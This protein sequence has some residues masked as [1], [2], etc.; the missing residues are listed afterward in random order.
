MRL[1][2]VIANMERII[3][4]ERLFEQG[5]TVVVAVSGGPD[6]VALLHVLF[7][8]SA[9]YDWSLVAAHVNHQFRGK[10]SDAEAEMVA[11]LANKLKIPLRVGVIDVPAYI[12]ETG[13]NPQAAA[14]EKR[15]A[16][17]HE[18]A[19][20]FAA[21]HIALAHH[22]DD[23]AET[24]IMRLLR[25]TGPSGLGGIPLRRRE[26]NVELVRPALRIYKEELLRH[27]AAYE[28][29]YCQDSSNEL[30]KY[31]RNRIR[32]DVL[33]YLRQ[34]NDQLPAALNRLA[35]TM[36]AED[37]YMEQETVRYF[38]E[39]V[40]CEEGKYLFKRPDF[41]ALPLALQRRLIK[42]ILDY[43]VF[44]MDSVDF[45]RL[46]SVREGIVREHP[47]N[48]HL[49]LH[50]G[51]KMERE[52][53]EI[54]FTRAVKSAVPRFCY[55]I[56]ESQLDSEHVLV[57]AGYKLSFS[58]VNAPFKEQEISSGIGDGARITASFDYD[59]L[60]FPLYVR[61]RADGDR[62][63][64]FGLNQSKKVKDIF[65]DA[66]L[67]PSRRNAIPLIADAADRIL[68]L[69]GFARSNAALIGTETKRKLYI[70]LTEM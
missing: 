47:P 48:V 17:L 1:M 69:P 30:R 56:S 5:D 43:L 35:E 45:T 3:K 4:A 60:R 64:L 19:Q 37:A 15:Y 31:A 27:C 22:A 33:P 44:T 57:E 21:S 54:C 20:E 52:Y 16:F 70:I 39:I 49:D 68:W 63:R 41:A 42:L 34:F 53:D 66:K 14:R 61:N 67:A 40:R 38:Q 6:S 23:Q 11:E 32:L 24:L 9:K 2:N 8:L 13:L 12:S 46:E 29:P 55:G 59:Q 65:I 58:V 62:I 51:I 26:K 25:G 50:D 18:A 36:T 28:L 10:E 7:L